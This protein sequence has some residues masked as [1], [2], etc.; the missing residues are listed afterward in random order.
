M[1]ERK[2]V[3]RTTSLPVRC[4]NCGRQFRLVIGLLDWEEAPEAKGG[5]KIP[6][7]GSPPTTNSA[8]DSLHLPPGHVRCLDCVH[9]DPK[10]YKDGMILC[11]KHNLY[12]AANLAR[13]CAHFLPRPKEKPAKSS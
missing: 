12:L 4:K 5:E 13:R 8:P 3:W 9:A 6:G 2:W 1:S 11:K 10:T 7:A